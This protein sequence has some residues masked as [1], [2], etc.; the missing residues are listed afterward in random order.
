[1]TSKIKRDT[2]TETIPVTIRIISW[3]VSLIKKDNLEPK[4]NQMPSTSKIIERRKMKRSMKMNKS[5]STMKKIKM[6]NKNKQV[7]AAINKIEKLR[8]YEVFVL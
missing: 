7:M 6:S 4:N 5:R 2:E 1:M 3:K 8:I